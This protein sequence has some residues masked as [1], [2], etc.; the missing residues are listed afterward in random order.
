MVKWLLAAVIVLWAFIP[1]PD[2]PI[3]PD[4]TAAE[5]Q[6]RKES[7]DLCYR[8]T[9]VDNPSQDEGAWAGRLDRFNDC[10]KG[11]SQPGHAIPNLTARTF[12][13]SFDADH[14]AQ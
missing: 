1:F 4:V 3:R 11:L 2:T 14:P 5:T 9:F 6:A 13:F 12:T 8:R 7:L 10:M